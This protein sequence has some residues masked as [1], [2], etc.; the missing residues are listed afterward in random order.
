MKNIEKYK[1]K[2]A[3]VGYDFALLEDNQIVNCKYHPTCIGCKFFAD[4]CTVPRMKWLLEES[5]LTDEEKRIIKDIIGAFI[6]LEPHTKLLCVRKNKWYS[7][8]TKC[9]LTFK[10]EDDSGDTPCFDSYKM[11]KGMKLNKEYTLEELGL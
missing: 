6:S 8:E 10:Y 11:F 9:Y 1:D 7:D 3:E 5:I 2:I 4:G